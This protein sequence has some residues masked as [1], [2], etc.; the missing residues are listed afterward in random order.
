MASDAP[1]TDPGTDHV[2]DHVTD[3]VAALMLDEAGPLPSRIA[4]V[5]DVGGTLARAALAR[6]VEVVAVCDDVR[7]E[8]ALPPGVAVAAAMEPSIFDNTDLVL[9]RLPRSLDAVSEV[10][11]TIAAGAPPSVRV[12][13]GGRVKHLTPT[14]NPVMGR[15]FASVRASLGRA[16]SRV[17]HLSGPLPGPVTWPRRSTLAEVGLDLVSYGQ[18]FATGRLD[19]GTALLA[20]HLPMGPGTAVDVGCGTGI[21]ATLLARY[22]WDVVASDVSSAAV[23]STSAT[24]AANG[25]TFSVG[26]WAAIPDEVRGRDLVFCNPPF[27]RAAAKDSSAAFDIIGDAGRALRPGGEL[28][29]VFNS[30][31]P[32]LP[33]ATRHVGP[34]RVVARDRSYVVTCSTRRGG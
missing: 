6:G 25:V 5:D 9:W 3:P 1:V 13:A 11:E 31:L 12:V 22:G 15:S 34:T 4:I 20:R 18:S 8:D 28:W 10:C 33:Y 2:T 27:H 14:M 32:Y 21:L 7:D 30:H 24:A 16:K 19:A 17:L 23:R 26:R 29:L